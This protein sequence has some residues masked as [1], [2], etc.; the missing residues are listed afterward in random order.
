MDAEGAVHSGAVNAQENA[1]RDAGPTRILGATVEAGLGGSDELMVRGQE[2]RLG[3][4]T[5]RKHST[6]A[7]VPPSHPK[8]T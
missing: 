5:P 2:W 8:E 3:A 7:P 6:S 4:D 1:V